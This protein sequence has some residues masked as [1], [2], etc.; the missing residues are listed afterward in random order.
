MALFVA[1]QQTT[2]PEKM[3]EALPRHL[4]FLKKTRDQGN[5]WVTG[6]FTDGSG[7]MTIYQADSL[8]EAT[9]LANED[10]FVKEGVARIEIHEWYDS[11][12]NL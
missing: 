11:K 1:V 2:S 9:R 10:P 6:P 7:G 8:E 3:Q 5:M 12:D 4:E